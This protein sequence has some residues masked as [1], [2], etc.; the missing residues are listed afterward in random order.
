ML[1]YFKKNLHFN[2]LSLKL[3]RFQKARVVLPKQNQFL[4][5]EFLLNKNSSLNAITL[6]LW[7]MTFHR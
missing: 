2:N 6:S 4:D 5:C 1:Q 7:I 3:Q